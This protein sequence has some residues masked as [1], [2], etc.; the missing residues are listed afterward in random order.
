MIQVH[1]S[2][3][4]QG[5][6]DTGD[7]GIRRVS[8][9]MI[10]YLPEFGIE[11]TG[12][13]ER[14]QIVIN[15]GGDNT[16]KKG[17]PSV[18]V[19]HGL[20]W[21]RQ[22]WEDV[23]Q[24]V[25]SQVVESMVRAVA[26]TAPS[27]WVS[28]AIRRGGLFYPEV[29]YHGVDAD[30]F[31]PAAETGNFV[32]WNKARADY[33][34]NP[35]DLAQIAYQMPGREFRS[36]VMRGGLTENVKLLGVTTYEQMKR[37][38][39]SAGVYLCTARETFG[40]GTLEAMACGVPVAGWDWGGQS[41][42]ILQGETGYLAPPGDYAALK[43]CIE[44]CFEQR[45]RLSANCIADV[46]ARW[47]WR[48]RIQ[49]YANIIQRVYEDFYGVQRPKVSVI[50]T[51]YHLDRYL[52]QCLESVS[53]QTFG[54]FECIVVDDARSEG[55]KSLVEEYARRDGRIIYKPTPLS[56]G[57][58]TSPQLEERKLGGEV[59][60]LGLPGARNYGFALAKGRY[61][62]HLD[63]DDFLAENALALEVTALDDDP[64]A[65]IVYG[66]LGTTTPDG[67]IE[68][69]RFGEATRGGWPPE[70]FDWVAQMAHLNQLPSCV[71]MRREVLE[72]SGG[73]RTRMRRQEDA[74]F[75]CRVTSL[76]FRAKKFTN[77]ITYYHRM[78]DDSKGAVEWQKE[79][80]EPD[81]TAWFPWRVGAGNFQ[82]GGRLL[83]QYA[84]LHPKPHLVPFFAQGRAPK[85]RFWYVHDHA[86][87]VVS[88]IVTV[89]PGH[90][91]YVVDALDSV[92]AQSFPDWECIV[93]NDTPSPLPL[94]RGARG[95]LDGF[96]W[97]RVVEMNG[98][99]GASA[100]R[101]AGYKHAR[102]KFIVWM[103]ADDIWLPWFLDLLVA[104]AEKN[105]GVIFSDMIVDTG[106][107]KRIARYPEFDSRR[108]VVDYLHAGTSV[109]IPRKVAEAV[110]AKQGG[111]DEQIPGKEDWDFQIAMYELGFCA[112]HVE[113]ALFV[114]RAWTSTKREADHA[115]MDEITR[116][117]DEKWRRYRVEG[118][119]IM[120]GCN[121]KKIVNMQPGSTLS[122]S[123]NFKVTDGAV[124]EEIRAKMVTVEFLGPET[125]TFTISGPVNPNRVNPRVAYRFGNNIHHKEA[126]VFWEDAEF[127]ISM[128]DGQGNPKW[129]IVNV[130]QAL[131]SR[132]A[133]AFLGAEISI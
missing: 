39:A 111:W 129:R 35:E 87:P 76:G 102:G 127:L 67:E 101:N 128:V 117:V 78:R 29:V 50:V 121:T 3:N 52:P 74:E 109:L 9:A 92:W 7:G 4:Y 69:D 81:W 104:H 94:S 108:A 120:C 26:H 123:G 63:A 68:K 79:G 40:I 86:Y 73:Y 5:K 116:Y 32:L 31:G 133:G 28:R 43:E 84:G 90:E 124:T 103:D 19:N 107:E 75:W 54:D 11:H 115:K 22:P 119:Q 130:A 61:I 70:K 126:T 118:V 12:N 25:N 58:V 93:V 37:I 82:D 46:R 59:S 105:D 18:N 96:P 71:M 17:A 60:P 47:G 66:H 132:D 112:Y 88:V 49:Q 44:K 64:G 1:I 114:Y 83:R 85:T 97:A 21:S 23:F 14:A 38:V 62:R 100:A 10:Q 6:P 91:A 34:S 56:P 48:P 55:T 33:V 65:H 113:E 98:N 72:R 13:Y 16:W 51:A 77:A 36:T 122:G 95:D 57:M 20:Y 24:Q 53:K 30:Q 41:E 8:E 89:G 42:I 131:G 99:K 2:P 80:Q 45:N 15:H 110:F 106:K 27:E 125:Q